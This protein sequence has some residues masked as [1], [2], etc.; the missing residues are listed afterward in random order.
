MAPSEDI[1]LDA[2][3]LIYI[4]KPGCPACIAFKSQWQT[5]INQ[6]GK[7]V[8]MVQFECAKQQDI[9][10]QLRVY[11]NVFPTIILAGPK[12]YY[13]IFN[14]DDSI[15]QNIFN[16]NGTM[17]PEYQSYTIK[18]EK[19]NAVKTSR[20]YE[21]GRT[22]HTAPNVADWL[23]LTIPKVSSYDDNQ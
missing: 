20:G 9:P 19:F 12:S 2:P 7:S 22:P 15:N 11:T 4:S 5:L 1:P 18:A 14:P 17:K 16:A 8:R 13:K 23:N 10:P 3:V 21:M 6:L